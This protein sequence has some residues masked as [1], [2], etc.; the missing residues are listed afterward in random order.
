MVEN[1]KSTIRRPYKDKQAVKGHVRV[2]I[3]TAG[4]INSY[5]MTSCCSVRTL[6]N[7]VPTANKIKLSVTV[8][9]LTV[10]QNNICLILV[11]VKQNTATNTYHEFELCN[12]LY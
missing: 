6:I 12:F 1:L 5:C 4:N 2:N 10:L 3:N 8:L 7:E 9:C 11:G